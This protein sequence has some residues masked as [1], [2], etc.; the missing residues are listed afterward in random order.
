M[1]FKDPQ[2][3][4]KY[5]KGYYENRRNNGICQMCQEP[6]AEGRTLCRTHANFQ[7]LA[8]RKRRKA[9][10]AKG[11]CPCGKEREAGKTKCRYCLDKHTQTEQRRAF[12]GNRL[13]AI[14][15]DGHKCLICGNSTRRMTVHHIDG[16]GTTSKH[17][18][19]NLD[20]LATLC[21]RC[22]NAFTTLCQKG[23]NISL[24]IAMLW[25]YDPNLHKGHA[26]ME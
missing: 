25:R 24:A 2:E 4:K 8:Q 22:H 12:E 1:P 3:R 26:V 20:N 19:N 6:V 11:L 10:K 7:S 21:L 23:N 15:R 5:I 9:N 13:K 14:E 16:N 17:Q 18:N